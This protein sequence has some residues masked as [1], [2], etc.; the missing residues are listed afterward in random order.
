[1]LFTWDPRK[2]TANAKKHGV[3]FGEAVTVFA[4]PLA[5]IV[6]DGVHPER[7]AIIGQSASLKVILVVYV[8]VVETQIRIISA[9]RTTAHE[10]KRYEEGA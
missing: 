1:M 9:R 4:D 8:D 6:E 7:S 3:S 10:R 5:F 2:A